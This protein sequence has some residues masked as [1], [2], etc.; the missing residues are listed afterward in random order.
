[1]AAKKFNH[2]VEKVLKECRSQMDM[3][4]DKWRQL[5]SLTAEFTVL[6]SISPEVSGGGMK[7]K[8]KVGNRPQCLESMDQRYVQDSISKLK[9]ELEVAH[10]KLYKFR[11]EMDRLA[12]SPDLK[13]SGRTV[14]M[15]IEW[16]KDI[17][18]R[19]KKGKT[20]YLR[21]VSS[22]I[23]DVNDFCT[24]SSTLNWIS[25]YLSELRSQVENMNATME[26]NT[27]IGSNLDQNDVLIGMLD[28]HQL[29]IER[30]TYIRRSIELRIIST[31][32][33]S[34][35]TQEDDF[36]VQALADA[37][38]LAENTEVNSDD[39]KADLLE[40]LR[41]DLEP[42]IFKNEDLSNFV[43]EEI[44]ERLPLNFDEV[45]AE[46]IESKTV[47]PKKASMCHK[48]E[49]TPRDSDSPP[50]AV[51]P[52]IKSASSPAVV[53]P[54][55][56][57]SSP[58]STVWSASPIQLPS[59]SVNER[60]CE[61]TCNP[62]PTDVKISSLRT[63]SRLPQPPVNAGQHDQEDLHQP[64]HF[65]H[66]H[67]VHSQPG[68]VSHDDEHQW[69]SV[70]DPYLN[71]VMDFHPWNQWLSDL[72]YNADPESIPS[73]ANHAPYNSMHF[74]LQVLN[75]VY[76]KDRR[77]IRSSIPK[78][79][80]DI[81]PHVHQLILDAHALQNSK[82]NNSHDEIKEHDEGSLTSDVIAIENWSEPG[83]LLSA[84][85]LNQLGLSSMESF[86]VG[87]N[88]RLLQAVRSGAIS[89]NETSWLQLSKG[90]MIQS[91]AVADN[92]WM[93]GRNRLTGFIGWF[94]AAVTTPVPQRSQSL[95][96]QYASMKFRDKARYLMN[97]SWVFT[98]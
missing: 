52:N 55:S 18:N 30:L 83:R 6:Q 46:E 45:Y 21:G 40:E 91:I 65:P 50:R 95:Y 24:S 33:Y 54:P 37:A 42:Y 36:V 9:N 51:T 39:D 43:C 93:F 7:A 34:Y 56:S 2:E 96:L 4:D 35:D 92:G 61:D 72:F 82:N 38:A 47:K 62:V 78:A 1:M 8:K 67:P 68:L 17:E 89:E 16:K 64:E 44:Y 28:I 20:F 13:N 59:A 14:Q 69:C 58:I 90:D 87:T 94:P 10:K 25:N 79:D 22:D 66:P 19:S 97:D 77:V 74:N 76:D 70:V 71:R 15:F 3:F 41:A 48:E 73:D 27:A 84:Y 49:S 32:G 5:R 12:A 86:E 60:P 81:L 85:Q 75:P 26:L 23:T 80:S 98:V 11:N 29:H 88:R 63:S 57:C 31:K 53:N